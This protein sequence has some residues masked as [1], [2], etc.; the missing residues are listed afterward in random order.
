MRTSLFSTAGPDGRARCSRPA[1]CL[2]VAA[3]ALL[4]T[5]LGGCGSLHDLFTSSDSAAQTGG[6]GPESPA[7]TTRP[8]DDDRKY[9][10]DVELEVWRDPAFRKRFAESYMSETEVEPRMSMED[11]ERMEKI[12][13]LISDEKMAEALD[14]LEQHRGKSSNAVY[15]F[16]RG[17]IYFSRDEFDKAAEAYATAVSKHPKFLR[18]WRNLSICHVRQ[19]DFAKA[20]RALVRVIELGGDD[21]TMYGLLGFTHSAMNNSVSAESAYRK[22]I[23]LAP[24]T[25]D[26]QMGLARC[27]FRQERFAE[28]VA[29][30]ERLIAE[31]PERPNLW[32]LQANAYIGAGKPLKAAENYEFVDRLG[33]S[34]PESLTT[35]GDIYVNEGLFGSA[36]D[37]YV[38][39][40][41]M[42][43]EKLAADTEKVPGVDR[44]MR[45]V[46]VLA[47]RGAHEEAQRLVRKIEEAFGDY[48]TDANRR[49]LLKLRAR[50]AVAQG[51]DEEAVKILKET[52]DRY[53]LDAEAQILL[54]QYYERQ[55]ES[56]RAMIHYERAA[57]VE[58]HEAE[59]KLRHGQL[60]VKESEYKKALPLLRRSHELKPREDLKEY[61]EQVER[62]ADSR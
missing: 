11:R 38:R 32:M 12:L 61:I 59:A 9:T 2:G 60:L 3:V 30:C 55:N 52:V 57:R 6:D 53:P 23:L 54:G 22:A 4:A 43:R 19:E 34:T 10:T 49:T 41:D 42:R 58:G 48:L 18:A 20:E 47:G 8:S 27:F 40:I 15:D 46:R 7:L 25:L 35:L 45:A 44:M 16:T 51:D 1:V 33:A 62:L 5:A 21:A 26:W 17:N 24:E 13:S 56:E 36:V 50:I 14:I 39:A 31:H 28:A 29:L 37:S